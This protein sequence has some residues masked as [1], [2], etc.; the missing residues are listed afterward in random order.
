MYVIRTDAVTAIEAFIH[1]VTGCIFHRKLLD[2]NVLPVC[3]ETGT[4]IKVYNILH[5][6]CTKAETSCK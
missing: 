4:L 3:T 1:P 5:I 2:I 6:L